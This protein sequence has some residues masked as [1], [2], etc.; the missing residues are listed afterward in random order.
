MDTQK[1]KTLMDKILE[2]QRRRRRYGLTSQQL[3]ELFKKPG[4][5]QRQTLS[6]QKI[7]R[8]DQRRP[9]IIQP[10]V[11]SIIDPSEMSLFFSGG[12]G[13]V[14]TLESFMTD[15][16]RSSL[17]TI[18]YGTNK[19]AAI[20]PLF[21]SLPNYPK[22]KNHI[23]VWNDFKDFWCFFSKEDCIRKMA[24]NGKACSENLRYAHDFS[25]SP[26]FADIRAGLLQFN[27]SSFLKH[28]VAS[29]EHFGLPASYLVICPFSTDKRIRSR[30]FNQDDWNQCFESLR[31]IGLKGVILNRGNDIIPNGKDLIDL[32]NRTTM[33]ES[34]EILKASK[35]YIGVD[36]ALSVIAAQKF[37]F[38]LLQVKCNNDHCFN[39]RQ[40]YY[41]SQTDSIFLVKYIRMPAELHS[42]SNKFN[43]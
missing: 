11:R 29:I 15:Q 1:H 18:Y 5:Q 27:G 36:S 25:I 14:V 31:T 38:P 4:V 20:E 16:Q 39:N 33:P 24:Q 30:D 17:S 37:Q 10:S 13:D 28:K 41:A 12:I 35:G 32:N 26:K 19:Q 21:K 43:Q 42:Y 8:N 2:A 6:Q 34:I 23:I 3:S 40:C 7:V 9:V 22:L